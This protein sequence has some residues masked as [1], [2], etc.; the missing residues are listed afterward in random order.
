MHINP[1]NSGSS[2]FLR[3]Y[4]W[5]L[6]GVVILVL[7]SYNYTSTNYRLKTFTYV[8]TIQSHDFGRTVTV[9]VKMK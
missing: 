4:A 1:L 2:I 8:N 5:L 7:Y 9:G 3:T 6:Y